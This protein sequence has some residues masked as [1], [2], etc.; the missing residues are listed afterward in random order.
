MGFPLPLPAS[1]GLPIEITPFIGRQGE[2]ARLQE[3]LRDP[4]VRLIALVGPGGVGKTRLAWEATAKLQAVFAQGIIFVPLAHLNTPAELLPALLE[5]LNIQLPLGGDL[6]RAI[7]DDLNSQHTLLILDNFE[8]LL[9]GALLVHEILAAAP[10]VKVLVTSREKL[11]LQGEVIYHLQGLGLPP[12]LAAGQVG[13]YDAVRLFIQKACQASPDYRLNDHDVP[14]VVRLCRLVDGMPLGILLAAA[15]MEQF[16]PQEITAQVE[17]DFDFLESQGRNTPPRHRSLRAVFD[18]SF[19]RLDGSLQT[20]FIRLAVF[21][22][23]FFLPAAAAVAGAELQS[24]LALVNK[25]L[26]SR[27]PA[28]A[29]YYLHELLSQYI[30]EKHTTEEYQSLRSAHS[31]YY[32]ELLNHHEATLKSG[33]QLAALDALQADFENIRHAWQ[34]AV[35]Q[36]DEPAIQRS[37]KSLYAFCDMRCRFYEGEALFRLAWQG[38]S[39]L[40]GQPPSSVLSLVLLSWIDLH[41]YIEKLAPSDELASLAQACYEQAKLAG[42]LEALA[43]SLVVLGALAEK[44]LNYPAAIQYYERGLQADPGLDDFYWI[45]LRIGLCYQLMSEYPLALQSFNRSLQRGKTL[46]ERVK[47]GWS[48]FNS[49]ETLLLQ[50]DVTGAEEY[51]SQAHDFFHETSTSVGILCSKYSL[52]R[53]A[54]AAD[55]PIR[56]KM[57][58]EAALQIAG[59][60]HSAAWANK[61]NDLLELIADKQPTELPGLSPSLVEPLS[62]RELE[63]LQLLKTDLSGPEIAHRMTVSLNTVRYHT[64]NIYQ[65]LQVNT[66]REALR[67]AVELGY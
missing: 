48:L 36:R 21:R 57:L 44:Q 62:S 23:G 14:A 59:Q 37:T 17:G 39:P 5:A 28:T 66:R 19:S 46:G 7:L 1:E 33:S 34:W 18:S 40:T 64:K 29:R 13:D 12:L 56:A 50:G 49:G 41:S 20:V 22:A 42:N 65:K 51:L 11:N 52:S 63:V 45:N 32:L 26:L 4:A 54:L 47:I 67:R 58:A 53:A 30:A 61:V 15:W 16:S 38:L 2:L 25:S 8:H 31:R 55:D 10:R 27:D 6:R 24:L 43:P 3:L 60:I 9:D 35:E